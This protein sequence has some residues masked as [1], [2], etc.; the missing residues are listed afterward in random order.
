[1]HACSTSLKSEFAKSSDH[2]AGG[3]PQRTELPLLW[4]NPQEPYGIAS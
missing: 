1:M 4:Q 3:N 2:V